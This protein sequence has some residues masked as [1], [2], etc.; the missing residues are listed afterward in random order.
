MKIGDLAIIKIK[1]NPRSESN[2]ER[3]RIHAR[4]PATEGE[5]RAWDVK[6]LDRDGND[7]YWEFDLQ[8]I[9]ETNSNG[10]II[11]NGK[12]FNFKQ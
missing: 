6:F 12:E 2:G 10:K 4:H 9:K 3:V 5:K 8:P 7:S 1:N 11:N